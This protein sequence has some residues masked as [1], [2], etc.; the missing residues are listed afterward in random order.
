M[1][2]ITH[3]AGERPYGH[4]QGRPSVSTR[5]LVVEEGGFLYDSESY[6]DELPYWTV[7]FGAPHLIIPYALDTNDI[8]L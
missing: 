1:D 6:A 4:Y 7:E 3:L 5:R 8:R 2:V